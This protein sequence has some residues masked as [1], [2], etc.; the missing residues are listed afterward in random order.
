MVKPRIS[1]VINADTRY[2]WLDDFTGVKNDGR[3]ILFGCRSIDFMTDG[4]VNKRRFL[5]GYDLETIVYVDEHEPLSRGA[6]K[7][8]DAMGESGEITKL[9]VTKVNHSRHRWNDYLYRDTLA[10]ATGD[11][12]A[13]FDGDAAAFRRPEFP[14]IEKYLAWLEGGYK[15]VCQQTPLPDHEHGMWWA[16]TRFFMCKRETL[17]L[18]EASRCIDDDY[19]R[20]KW[21]DR[22]CPCFEHIIALIAGGP[23]LY[24]P[25]NNDNFVVVNWVAYNRGVLSKLNAMDYEGV[26]QYIFEICGGPHGAS[27]VIGQP[28]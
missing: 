19:R 11:Y 10:H 1:L 5:A 12:I 4:V 3:N 7:R 15:Y 25:S 18:D 17:D 14:L 23:V 2:G 24:P 28:L 22:H 21:G 16:S 6:V 20:A 13:H 26:K 8:L 27:D 9:I